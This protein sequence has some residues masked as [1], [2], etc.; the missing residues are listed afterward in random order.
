MKK[1]PI[2]PV[3]SCVFSGVVIVSLIQLSNRYALLPS[4]KVLIYDA[5]L[6]TPQ[7]F[8]STPA[9]IC[10]LIGTICNVIMLILMIISSF[11]KK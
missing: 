1:L 9:G 7:P 2:Y 6:T 4:E 11:R 3:L 10:V 8:L 5:P